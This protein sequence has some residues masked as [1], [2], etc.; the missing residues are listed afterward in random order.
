MKRTPQVLSAILILSLVACGKDETAQ[1]A[2]NVSDAAS[3][4]ADT[5][6]EQLDIATP[7]GPRPTREEMER[8]RFNNE[9]Q[10]LE[11]FKQAAARRQAAQQQRAAAPATGGPKFVTIQPG[12]KSTETLKGVN[13]AAIND[14]PVVVPVR[15]D[16]EGPSVLRTQILLDRNRFSVAAIDGRWG[17]N[18]A[19]AVYWFQQTKGLTPTGDVDEQTFR[20]LMDGAG[21]LPLMREYTVAAE[22][23]KGP[24]KKIPEDVYDQEKLDCLCYETPLEALA[25][26]FHVTQD[27]LQ[28]LNPSVKPEAI[29][30]GQKLWV[31]NTR[32]AAPENAGKDIQRITVSVKGSYLHGLDAAGNVVFHAP[33][34]LGSKYDP[35]PNETVK[36]VKTAHDPHFHYQPTLFHEV[37]DSD[38]EA[39]LKPGPNSPVGVVWMALSKKHFGIHGTNDPESIGYAASHGCVR[40]ANWDAREVAYRAPEGIQVAFIDTRSSAAATAVAKQQ[41]SG[42][43]QQ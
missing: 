38:P 14:A 27:L 37:P 26:K 35:S 30:A 17:K 22:D 39:N 33:T 34:T 24:F 9:W 21:A 40:L 13:P 23:V 4:A 18:S 7:T 1:V 3:N 43:N 41:P 5:V 11:S 20:A 31:P 12:Q 28:Q 19:I 42:G 8:E 25:E 10:Q 32:E 16:V 2:D 29:A 15:G 36:L 6:K